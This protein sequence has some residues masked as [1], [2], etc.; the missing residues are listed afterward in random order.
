MEA[1][2]L[3][4]AVF[5]LGPEAGLALVSSLEGVAALVLTRAGERRAS[6]DWPSR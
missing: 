2:A 6:A 1:D 5:A 4:T 3:A